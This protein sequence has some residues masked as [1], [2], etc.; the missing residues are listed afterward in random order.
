VN[1]ARR[2]LAA[3]RGRSSL[4][5]LQRSVFEEF[6]QC[7]L[8]EVLLIAHLYQFLERILR[9]SA[10]REGGGDGQP[11][12]EAFRMWRAL[13]H[14]RRPLELPGSCL[15]PSASG[16]A[17]HTSCHPRQGLRPLIAKPRGR[18]ES[19]SALKGCSTHRIG[20]FWCGGPGRINRDGTSTRN[21]RSADSHQDPH[22]H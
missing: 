7:A 8:S 4:E 1:A 17:E 18:S 3:D 14:R 22:H 6:P 12:A 20:A 9:R 5:S 15:R 21:P 10:R 16:L 13:M 11:R 2:S 19:S